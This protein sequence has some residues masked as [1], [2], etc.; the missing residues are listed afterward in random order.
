MMMD[1]PVFSRDQLVSSA[2]AAKKFGAVRKK[3]QEKPQFITDNG[4]VDSVI[5][6]I[7]YFEQM[8]SRLKELE[9]QEE[10]RILL[11]RI[12]RLE[13]YPDSAIPWKA[14]KRT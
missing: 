13:K 4:H 12:E 10:N 1:K 3:A 7:E 8:F 11:E 9:K 6:G 14:V 5:L 2:D